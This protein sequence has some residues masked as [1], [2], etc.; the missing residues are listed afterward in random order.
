MGSTQANCGCRPARGEEFCQDRRS[1]IA[2]TALLG[3]IYLF[4][5]NVSPDELDFDWD[6]GFLG[7]YLFSVGMIAFTFV[8]QPWLWKFSRSVYTIS[9]KGVRWQG[10]SKVW[11]LKWS[12]VESYSITQSELFPD[13]QLLALHT[14]RNKKQIP[15]PEGPLAHEIINTVAANV[16]MRVSPDA[17]AT[18]TGFSKGFT[19][20]RRQYGFLYMTTLLYSVGLASYLDY[21][22]M[23]NTHKELAP[24]PLLLS[25]VLGGGTTGVILLFGRRAFKEK[26][27]VSCIIVLNLATLCLT[28][29]FFVLFAFYHL[30]KLVEQ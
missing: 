4:L 18:A 6:N 1:E 2:G 8:V 22:F 20:S 3:G 28:M 23:N 16:G 11:F 10:S 24:L 17:D 30:S 15:L 19:L 7:M 27:L 26:Q 29:F 9:E 21:C 13:I 5:K 12:A 25:L 14:R